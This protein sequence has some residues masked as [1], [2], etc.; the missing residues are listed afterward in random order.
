MLIA[1]IL[2]VFF[3]ERGEHRIEHTIAVVS[4]TGLYIRCSGPEDSELMRGAKVTFDHRH[5][6]RKVVVFFLV[7]R[8]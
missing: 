3:S 5:Y 6:G 2:L 7:K 8:P 1:A 4:A